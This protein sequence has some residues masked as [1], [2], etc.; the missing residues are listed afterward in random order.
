M[1]DNKGIAW[2]MGVHLGIHK[3]EADCVPKA[4]PSVTQACRRVGAARVKA[5]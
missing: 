2:V 5:F 1:A 3:P 4:L